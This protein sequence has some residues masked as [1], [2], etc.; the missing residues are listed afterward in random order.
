MKL[1]PHLPRYAPLARKAAPNSAESS[2]LP[3]CFNDKSTMKTLFPGRA[4][5][6]KANQAR[7]DYLKQ[8]LLSTTSCSWRVG[9]AG[10]G[11][12]GQ[13]RPC[14]SEVMS[15]GEQINDALWAQVLGCLTA[16]HFWEWQ[17]PQPDVSF[18]ISLGLTLNYSLSCW[19]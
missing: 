1:E 19:S 3:T 17:P 15:E 4:K 2:C 12:A 10:C 6:Q 5:H 7:W 8:S 18:Q 14:P 9:G 11:Q 13:V 16:H